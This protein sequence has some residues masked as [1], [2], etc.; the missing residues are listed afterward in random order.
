MFFKKKK[1]N[2]PQEKIRALDRRGIKYATERNGEN[3]N[4]THVGEAGAINLENNEFMLVCGG[5]NIIRCDAGKVRVSELMNLSGIV[6][7][8]FDKDTKKERTIIAYF[9]DGAVKVK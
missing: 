4:E 7:K 6:I 1:Y 8:G 5:K 2:M 3:Y 9:S